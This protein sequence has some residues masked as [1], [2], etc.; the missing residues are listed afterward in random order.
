[1]ADEEPMSLDELAAEGDAIEA[2]EG[3]GTLE[4]IAN[5]EA[6]RG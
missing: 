6:P 5:I 4:L 2:G 3:E 1:M